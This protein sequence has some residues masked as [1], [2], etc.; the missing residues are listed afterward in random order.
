MATRLYLCAA[1]LPDNEALVPAFAAWTTTASA[2]RRAMVPQSVAGEYSGYTDAIATGASV[3]STAAQSAAHRQYISLPMVAGIAW[4]N[5]ASTFGCQIMGLESAANDN[6]IN[7]VRCVKVVSRDGGTLRATL[8]ALGNAA[9]VVEWN[10]TLRNLTFLNATAVGANYT[11]VA[12]DRLV[13]EVGHNDSAGV[14]IAGQMAFGITGQTGDLGVNETDTTATLRPWLESSV[15]LTFEKSM[16]P[17]RNDRRYLVA[18][19]FD[20][21]STTGWTP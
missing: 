5:A 15:N 8:I 1:R 6:I 18:R 3:S 21:F 16:P 19:D 13:L 4:V 2:V 10:T 7:R 9:A 11:T 14:S 12:G 20:A 17:A